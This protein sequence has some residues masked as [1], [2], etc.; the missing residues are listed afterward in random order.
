VAGV[1]AL[2]RIAPAAVAA[3]AGERRRGIE[4]KDRAGCRQ[5][6]R[7]TDRLRV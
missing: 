2:S 3:G 6:V 4:E 5:R 7:K 1:V